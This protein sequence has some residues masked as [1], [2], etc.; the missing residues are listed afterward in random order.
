MKAFSTLEIMEVSVPPHVRHAMLNDDIVE[1]R[2]YQLEAVDEALSSSMLLVMPTA[3]G[4]TAVIWMMISEKL[5]KGGRGIMIAPT[6]GLVEQHIR[7]MRDVLKLEDEIIS[8]TG[9]IPPSKR[10]GKWTEARLI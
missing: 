8:I 4:K 6:V 1:A 5:A 10:S 9:Q 3:A 2:A 7:S